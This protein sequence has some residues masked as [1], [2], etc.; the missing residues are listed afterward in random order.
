MLNIPKNCCGCGACTKACPKN[1]IAMQPNGEGFLY[2]YV[3]S[4]ICVDCGICNKVCP[5]G[6]AQRKE[7]SPSAFAAVCVDETIRSTSSSGGVFSLIAEAVINDGGAVFGAA[8]DSNF[9]VCHIK[10]ESI[11]QLTALRTS[12]Y[13]QSDLGNCYAEAEQLLK[14]GRKVLFT[15]TACQISGLLGYLR[16]EYEG[17]ITQ[18]VFCL[19]V[20]SP[21]VWD[22]YKKFR[23]TGR[24]LT[25]ISFRHKLPEE[26]TYALRFQFA[27]GSELI[28]RSSTC[29]YTK[30]FV[31]RLCLRESCYDCAF[32]GLS[33][34]SDITLADFW[35]VE[36][37]APELDDGKGVSLVLIHSEKGRAVFDS[38]SAML[39]TK[40]VNATL[41]VES[42]PMAVQ[43][44]YREKNRD[45]FMQKYKK[46]G[47]DKALY[48][49][50]MPSLKIRIKRKI[51]KLFTL[52]QNK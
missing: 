46:N 4:S 41:A 12:K 48:K 5:V 3:D 26:K 16:H 40:K 14:D 18:D 10:A 34:S 31:G 7:T 50:E 38:I 24:E 33:R 42:N 25:A 44:A 27:D 21:A 19:G 32:K 43:S 20:P 22:E 15:G 39:R 17:L 9:R 28:E 52:I 49:C 35:G 30:A 37:H 13:V 45:L 6:K 47:F 8:F 2:P 11:D 29:L 1:C 51:K 36:S 23:A